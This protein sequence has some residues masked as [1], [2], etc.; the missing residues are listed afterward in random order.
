LIIKNREDLVSSGFR[1]RAVELIEAGITRVLPSNLLRAAIKYHGSR[2]KLIVGGGVYDVSRGRLF[3]VGGGKAAGLMAEEIENIIGPDNIT[4][5]IVNCKTGDYK[6]SRIEVLKAGH[7]VPDDA[8]VYG[9]RSM[10]AMK[11]RYNIGKGDL[12]LCLISGGGSALMPCPVGDVTLDDKQRI[13]QLLLRCGANIKEINMVRKHLSLTKG[14][15][16]GKYYDPARVVS[17]IISDVVGDDLETI[18]SGPTVPDLSTFDDAYRVL[19]KY[20]LTRKAPSNA[21]T[22]INRGRD[23]LEAETPKELYN[24]DNYIIGN[25][26]MALAAMEEK[27]KDM[28]LRP[29]TITSELTGD[30]SEAAVRFAQEITA[31]QY[32]GFN[33][34]LLGGETTPTLTDKSGKGGRNQ[35]YAA[36]SMLAMRDCEPPW[37]VAAIGTDG[38]DYL[39]DVAGAMVDDRSLE[40]AEAAGIDVDDYVNRF[41]SYT[42]FRRMGRSLIVTGATGTNVSDVLFYLLD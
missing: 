3:V 24:C 38:S 40:T 39:P 13:T 9:V 36:V 31:G 21:V 29:Y 10:L 7:P 12:V 42:L 41:D 1:A 34:I 18:A 22:F 11:G 27:A 2:K 30:T 6:T 4:A 28:G 25:N 23:G 33:V 14:G 37:L 32:K 20:K 8:G 35:H 5:G 19:E 15:S 17:L 16:L 26:S